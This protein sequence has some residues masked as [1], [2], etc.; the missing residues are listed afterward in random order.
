MA[1]EYPV[2]AF[3]FLFDTHDIKKE[4]KYTGIIIDATAS[5]I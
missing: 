3:S 1:I 2:Y 5:M 4:G